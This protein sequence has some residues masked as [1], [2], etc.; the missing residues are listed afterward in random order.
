MAI[1]SNCLFCNKKFIPTINSVGKY[2][3]TV[4]YHKSTKTGRIK[5]CKQCGNPF[6]VYKSRINREFCSVECRR[7]FKKVIKICAVCGKEFKVYKSIAN[8]YN[9]CSKKCRLAFTVYKNCET[10]GKRFRDSNNRRR[11]CSE[12]C[13]RPETYIDCLTCGRRFRISPSEINRKRFCSFSCYRKYT[14]ETSLETVLRNC[15]NKNNIDFLQEFQIG[16]YSID[17][18]VPHNI[19][20]EADSIYWH[21][22]PYVKKRDEEKDR[23]LSKN[24]FKILRF[25]ESEIK[26]DPQVCIDKINEARAI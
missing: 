6:Y 9:V 5:N 12:K 4:C 23:I 24:G 21:S 22:F 3:S 15:L 14:G 16:H 2:C 1:E 11:H 20:I 8:R 19:C 10:C 17:F 7:E 18:F 25:G 26:A 13:R